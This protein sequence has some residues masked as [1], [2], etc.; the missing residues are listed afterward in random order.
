MIEPTARVYRCFDAAGALLYVGVSMGPT[1]R[2]KAHA[3]TS[4]WFGEVAN[5]TISPVMPRREALEAERDAIAAEKPIHNK[6]V[7]PRV[8]LPPITEVAS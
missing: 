1:S 8:V 5:V 6:P 4:P 7:K 3:R 2:L